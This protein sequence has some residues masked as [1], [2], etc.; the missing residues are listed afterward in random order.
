MAEHL[1]PDQLTRYVKRELPPAELIAADEHL[2]SCEPCRQSATKPQRLEAMFAFLRHDLETQQRPES[3]VE[4]E[5]LEAYVDNR[6]DEADREIVDSHVELCQK[7]REEL[8][9]LQKSLVSLAARE[10]A[11]HF[12][13]QRTVEPL[14]VHG[15]ASGQDDA[16]L[17]R[18]SGPTDSVWER[19]SHFWRYPGYLG[20]VASA[21][22][23][24]LVAVL[25]VPHRQSASK[26]PNASTQSGTSSPEQG[27]PA[28]PESRQELQTPAELA[29]LI[30]KTATLLGSGTHDA[31]F[32][33]QTP[34]GTFVENVQPTFRWQPLAGAA[35]YKVTVFDA[36]LDKV[37][38]SPAVSTTDWKSTT[39]L[40]RGK[41]YLWQVSATK[42]GEQVVAPAPPAP[43]ARFEI[44]DLS[45][46]NSLAQLKREQ[47][48]AHFAL[49]RAY[50]S[51]GVL[52]EAEREFR[53]VSGS[54]ADYALAQKFILDLEGLR[55]P[56]H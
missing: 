21:V 30:G 26:Q 49:G 12:D 45:E 32:R 40:Q 15:A 10:A 27:S 55:H 39:P 8:G 19:V 7:C 13:Q 18:K 20:G 38:A 6:A 53:L 2:S 31:S 14:T 36:A 34:V 44:L 48:D 3:H 5:Q 33:L 46:A 41:I 16:A 52:D 11:S 54:E 4:Y 42:S 51:C 17:T 25:F 43:E 50:A 37:A 22:A 23:I 28:V 47:P 35:S 56:G 9:D 29:S 24:V 1:T